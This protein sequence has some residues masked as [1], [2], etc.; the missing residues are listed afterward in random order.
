MANYSARADSPLLSGLKEKK[1]VSLDIRYDYSMN[2]EGKPK[3]SQTVYFGYITTPEN[4]KSGAD[5][6]TFPTSF[7][8]NE[9]TGSYT[10]IN[11]T[12]S[13]T[14][15]GVSAPIRLSWRTVPET[16]WGANN[17]T[18]WLYIDNIKV[19]IKK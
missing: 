5:T 10:N 9:T 15:S 17:N 16:N 6:G 7:T 8:V 18:C 1:T 14:L 12:A 13:T 3:I 4:P 2:R 19:K 11:H